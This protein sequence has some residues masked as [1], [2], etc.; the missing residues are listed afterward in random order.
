MVGPIAPVIET[1]VYAE[2]PVAP[3]STS[4]G[5]L[6]GNFLRATKPVAPSASAIQLEADRAYTE[7]FQ[8]AEKAKDEG[9][10]VGADKIMSDAVIN[11]TMSGQ[12]LSDEQ[13]IF[14]TS[15]TGKTLA[16]SLG[17]D[18]AQAEK[19][20]W[21]ATPEGQG[22]LVVAQRTLDET[23]KDYTQENVT[24]LAFAERDN[25][26]AAQVLFSRNMAN[27]KAGQMP[28]GRDVFTA[29][30]EDQKLITFNISKA[31][32]DG[33]VTEEERL[34]VQEFF[35][36]MVLEKYNSM[37]GNPEVSS[38]LDTLQ[39]TVD[40]LGTGPLDS[41]KHTLEALTEP[42]LKNGDITQLQLM[43]LTNIAE[44][45][46]SHLV[47]AGIVD[48]S[49]V[50]AA[51]DTLGQGAV[52][53]SFSPK[54]FTSLESIEEEVD[55]TIALSE[56]NEEAEAHEATYINSLLVLNSADLS[57]TL[58]ENLKVQ[59]TYYKQVAS[60]L[61]HIEKLP[62]KILRKGDRDLLLDST[63]LENLK[64]YMS[65]KPTKGGELLDLYG[66]AVA[67]ELNRLD[68]MISAV[69]KDFILI[70]PVS[71]E[72][73]F[74]EKR[75]EAEGLEKGW[76]PELV[77]TILD[78]VSEAGGLSEWY[79]LSGSDRRFKYNDVSIGIETLTNKLGISEPD[80][81][82]ITKLIPDRRKLMDAVED[83]EITHL[84]ETAIASSIPVETPEVED[85]VEAT[86][87]G[88]LGSEKAPYKFEGMSD[89][90]QGEAIRS[91]SV[92]SFF[93][94]PEDGVVYEVL[95]SGYRNP[96]TR[97][98]FK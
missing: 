9:N 75:I 45:G 15:I 56:A 95:S 17:V 19:E 37:R 25:Y 1:Q 43:A 6:F 11:L 41:T 33:R 64:T 29:L 31:L 70:D 27:V 51:L 50:T 62:E 26:L 54:V 30:A 58:R 85:S 28:N 13:R 7:A 63:F 72:Y 36:T 48:L 20:A 96:K 73:H 53:T 86:E 40:V 66:R 5:E 81:E 57:N 80:L 67:A 60:T 3:P 59:E 83:L 98:V 93:V 74:D 12:S 88:K 14:F 35:R 52:D 87:L 10:H 77:D 94:N 69:G 47:A 49:G 22:F 89:D 76:P 23:G 38:Y 61:F 92:G 42:L 8:S 65:L 21:L 18:P 97:E 46:Q 44:T 16:S 90:Q 2:R 91:L 34:G 79:K 71:K 24:A 68:T 82:R 84:V 78:K 55:K 32:D 39:A 4:M